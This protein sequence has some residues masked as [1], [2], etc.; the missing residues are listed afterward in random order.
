[1]K[2]RISSQKGRRV[3]KVK[4]EALRGYR[5]SYHEKAGSELAVFGTIAGFEGREREL[6]TRERGRKR[7]I[8]TR[9]PSVSIVSRYRWNLGS[10]H[11]FHFSQSCPP[12]FSL[13]DS[14]RR[15][16]SPRPTRHDDPAR[17]KRPHPNAPRCLNRL[18]QSPL[19]R[20]PRSLSILPHQIAYPRLS[21]HQLVFPLD[22]LDASRTRRQ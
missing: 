7:I 19:A 2:A 22:S 20:Q 17:P 6:R 21:F 4:V 1:M 18:V 13:K 9:A 11:G 15:R 12:T 3:K 5:G 8:H 16:P 14:L 10:P